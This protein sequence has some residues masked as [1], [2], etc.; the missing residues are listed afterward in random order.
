[1]QNRNE[2]IKK[3]KNSCYVGKTPLSGGQ[4][5]KFPENWFISHVIALKPFIEAAN[6]NAFENTFCSSFTDWWL[7]WY[8]NE[9]TEYEFMSP[10][11]P[12]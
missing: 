1:M 6:K 10:S 2:N 12:P 11:I 8:K 7:R 5:N 4:R 3:K 9:Y